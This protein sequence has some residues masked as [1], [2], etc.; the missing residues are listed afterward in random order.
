MSIS[1][2]TWI[3]QPR[4]RFDASPEGIVAGLLVDLAVRGWR[5]RYG[6]ALGFLR[7]SQALPFLRIVYLDRWDERDAW[8]RAAVLVHEHTHVRQWGAGWRRWWRGALYLALPGVRWR[9]EVEA[10]A[11]EAVACGWVLDDVEIDPR[12]SGWRWPY[13]TGASAAKVRALLVER[14]GALVGA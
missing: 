8:D 12:L 4:I 1:S 3:Y 14:V 13:L 6:R 10:M 5:V 2:L 9:V 7:L 11:H